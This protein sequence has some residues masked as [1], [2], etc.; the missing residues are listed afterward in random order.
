MREVLGDDVIYVPLSAGIPISES[1][2]LK[3]FAETGIVGLLAALWLLVVAARMLWSSARRY[4][5]AILPSSPL[6][7]LSSMDL[8]PNNGVVLGR[9]A[10]LGPPRRRSRIYA[11]GY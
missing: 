6:G 2:V 10:F 3:V 4:E 7:P 1:N 8:S 11:H 5:G 9:R